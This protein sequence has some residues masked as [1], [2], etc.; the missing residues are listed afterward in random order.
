MGLRH[1]ISPPTISTLRILGIR[2]RSA[3]EGADWVIG[4]ESQADTGEPDA[5]PEATSGMD[6]AHNLAVRDRTSPCGRG[7]YHSPAGKYEQLKTEQ[8]YSI[9][10]G[11]ISTMFVPG[12][13]LWSYRS[14]I[15]AANFSDPAFSDRSDNGQ[16]GRQ[17]LSGRDHSDRRSCHRRGCHRAGA[18]GIS[19][20]PLL[21]PDGMPA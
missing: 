1:G 5:P 21:A 10:D 3:V 9:D 20:I 2:Y 8:N 12:K 6:P 4:A 14:V 11:D 17:R 7:S 16:H 13:D 18:S 15:A 19:G